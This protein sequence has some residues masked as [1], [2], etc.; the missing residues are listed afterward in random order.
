MRE[1]TGEASKSAALASSAAAVPQLS[2]AQFAR[3]TAYAVPELVAVGDVVF[4]PGDIDYDLIVIE[5]G[6]I[7]IVSPASRDDAEAVVAVYEGGGFLGELNFLTGQTAYLIGRVADAG[8]IHRISRE[9]F[10]RVLGEDPEVSD[11]LVRTFLARRDLLRGGAA[12]RGITILGSGQSSESLALRTFAA[13]QRLPHLW[14]DAD[15]AAGRALIDSAHLLS[16][17]LPAVFTPH[18]VLRAATPGEM[19][20]LLGLSYRR[21][22][23]DLVDLTVIGSGP[24]GLGAAVYGASEG[25][26]TVLL[27]AIGIG[28][29]AAASSCIENYL[30]FP[31]GLSGH[32][33][34]RRAALQAMKFGAQLSSPCR[35]VDLDTSG[36]HLSVTLSDGKTID[37]RAVL[38]ASGVRYR[39][40][41]IPRWNHFEGAGIYYAATELEARACG[42]QPVTV[43]GGANSAGQ[44]ALYLASRGSPVILAVRGPDASATM[45]SY[46]L[47]RIMADPR[48]TMRTKS[49]VTALNGNTALDSITLTDTTSGTSAAQPCFGLFCFIGAEPAT[50]WLHDVDL[51]ADGFIRTDTQLDPDTLGATWAALGRAPLP[52]ET[53]MPGVFAAGDVRLA[54]VK[55][56]ASAVGEGASAVR[57]IHAAIGVRA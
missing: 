32:D 19:A 44:A 13:R 39:S 56:V 17:D 34:T 46:L 29:Q 25:L 27:D 11:I 33:L 15:S 37:T 36:A 53:S 41:P 43:I 20:Q 3:L 12:A 1:A 4:S 42:T 26:D 8:R 22:T 21:N 28:G 50:D 2:T 18:D 5:S 55:R 47:G 40:L 6:R 57:S 49:E 54:S 10:R 51:D 31:S 35:V 38:I 30:G 23:N 7:E 45:S 48:I 24:A 16:S 14:L 9:Q 52:F